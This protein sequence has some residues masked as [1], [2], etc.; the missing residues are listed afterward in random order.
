MSIYLYMHTTGSTESSDVS[1]H[2]ASPVEVYETGVLEVVAISHLRHC[3][4][5][6]YCCCWYCYYYFYCWYCYHYS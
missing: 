6:Y 1:S 3:C 4:Y 2:G 5:R